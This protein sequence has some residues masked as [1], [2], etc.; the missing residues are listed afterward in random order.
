MMVTITDLKEQ[1]DERT[2]EI[3]HLT[4]NNEAQGPQRLLQY[5]YD[6]LQLTNQK[7]LNNNG[8]QVRSH[9]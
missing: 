5:V 4:T 9:F 8:S 3:K 7:L 6:Q 2:T 1:L